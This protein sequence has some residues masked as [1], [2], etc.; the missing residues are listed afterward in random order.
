MPDETP[1]VRPDVAAVLKMMAASEQPPLD[2]LPLDQARRAMDGMQELVELPAH[3]LAVIEDLACPGPAGDIPLRLYDAR[4]V[5]APGPVIL[6]IHGGGFVIGDLD[7]Y[8]NLCTEIALRTDLPVL[9]VDYRLAPE[10]P[11]P[12][13]PD[14]VEA[15]ARWAAGSPTALGRVVTG[16]IPMGDSAGGNLTLVTTQSLMLQPATV[17]VIAQVPLYPLTDDI[18]GHPSYTEF[19][20]GYLLTSRAMKWFT[21]C[22]NPTPGDRRN[23][24]ILGPLENTPP[25]ILATAGLDPL[26]DSGRNFAARLIQ[27]GCDVTY[28]EMSGNIHAFANLR[29]A[30]PSAQKDLLAILGA[31]KNTLERL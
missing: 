8:H 26:R 20:E 28:L 16:L 21:E 22:Y 5:R 7:S 25:T 12:A 31:L 13:A 10:N 17:P 6:F 4:D 19:G 14:D 27:A 3:D 30:I 11:F 24:P 9:S 18:A 23:L 1:F 29:K 15:A 2:T